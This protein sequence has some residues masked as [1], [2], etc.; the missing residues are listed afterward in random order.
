MVY[1]AVLARIKKRN[2][3]PAFRIDCL[4]RVAL[5]HIAGS[6]TQGQVRIFI[7]SAVSRRHNVLDLERK[8]KNSF[9]R[10]AVLAPVAGSLGNAAVLRTHF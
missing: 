9:G 6:A 10:L 2:D 5:E 4:K 7:G 8:I 1:P 3:S